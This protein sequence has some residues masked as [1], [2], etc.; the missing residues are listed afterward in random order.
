MPSES[1]FSDGILFSGS[2]K[3]TDTA[4]PFAHHLHNRIQRFTLVRQ[5]VFHFGRNLR[6]FGAYNQSVFFHVF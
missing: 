5:A 4:R 6:V 1:I 2:L 3:L